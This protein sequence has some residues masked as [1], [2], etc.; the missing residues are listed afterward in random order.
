MSAAGP[1]APSL[2]GV[3][4]R[5]TA[6]QAAGKAVVLAAGA[7]SIAVT[8]RY[9]GAA[10]YGRFALALALLQS[11]GVLADAGLVT[12]VVR[13]SSRAPARTAELVANA[14][15]LRLAL[16]PLVV[17]LATAASG[18]AG[19]GPDVRTAVLISAAPF[20][21]GIVSSSL[22]A[23]FQVRLQM[24]R[25]ALA[26]AGGRVA[27]LGALL[28]VVAADLGFAAV[29]AATAVG[30]AVTLAATAAFV[31]RIVPLRIAADRTIWREL[32]R[33]ALPLGLTLAVTE[34]YF[35]ADTFI[36]SLARPA[37]EVG[38]YTLAY[39]LYELLA[40]FPAIVMTSVFPLLSRQLADDRAAAQRTLGATAGAFW[41]LGAPL[42]AGGLLVAPE[43]AR[44]AGGD[45]FAAAADPLRLLLCAAALAYVSGL[46]GYTLVAGGQQR[47]ALRL[48]LVALAANVALNLALT[49]AYGAT[50]AAA[51]ALASEVLLLAGGWALL[52][53]RLG[54]R[55]GGPAP[56]RALAAAAVMAAALWPLRDRTLALTVPLGAA[57]YG[58]AL[59]RSEASTAATWSCCGDEDLR[60]GGLG[61]ADRDAHGRAGDPRL[62][63]G[64]RAR[65]RMRRDGGRARSER[66]RRPAARPR[67]GRHGR[68]GGARAAAR[69]HDVVIAQELPP[70][71]L[72]RLAGSP[73][74]LVAD[75]YNAVVVELLEGAAERPAAEQRRIG[76][77]SPRARWRS[78]RRRTS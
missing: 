43:L 19:Y 50:A 58:L 23:V 3:V 45:D 65:R 27:G 28:A 13:E 62:R 68:S 73:T 14:L 78:A 77:G 72:E 51:V 33:A 44:T 38:H 55:L 39:R 30:A 16:A 37:E 11:L 20:A 18:L 8:T 57:A 2:A 41:T 56:W 5:N 75:L 40:M 48:A 76:R 74:R 29:V 15:A 34:L 61:G 52:R 54:L 53:R 1:A 69:E 63:A 10:G 9:L 7:A 64:A 71:A 12:L 60:A 66:A 6:A 70:V 47:S 46:L 49:P 21:M 32:A 35:R 22:A 67:R 4:A 59:G 31:R 24:G 17:G 36:L 42:A 26:D 25:A